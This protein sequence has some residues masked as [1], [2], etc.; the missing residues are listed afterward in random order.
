MFRINNTNFSCSP[1][2][3]NTNKVIA[4]KCG[5]SRNVENFEQ[6]IILGKKYVCPGNRDNSELSN[7]G[8]KDEIYL[9]RKSA[10]PT[11]F[12]V[13]QSDTTL[14]TYGK[15]WLYLM[16]GP[17]IPKYT[18]L[19]RY[20]REAKAGWSNDD[21]VQIVNNPAGLEPAGLGVINIFKVGGPFVTQMSND[22][23]TNS[24]DSSGAYKPSD[25]DKY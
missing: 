7:H 20:N 14:G 25:A 8:I 11:P 15:D 2:M 9:D 18:Y 19:I 22:I 1:M 23:M 24:Y 3:N 17:G 6:P 4:Y 13:D 5:G 21:I 16:T 10:N 12:D